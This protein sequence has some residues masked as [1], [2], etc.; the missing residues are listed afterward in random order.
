MLTGPKQLGPQAYKPEASQRQILALRDVVS[1]GESSSLTGPQTLDTLKCV[2]PVHNFAFYNLLTH[3]QHTGLHTDVGS[4]LLIMALFRWKWGMQSS[5]LR[6]TTYRVSGNEDMT[7]NG[8]IWDVEMFA[9]AVNR[10][11]LYQCLC[12]AENVSWLEWNCVFVPQVPLENKSIFSGSLFQYLEENKKW[13]NRFL[14]IPDSYNI[15]YYDN[16]AVNGNSNA[17]IMCLRRYWFG[18][19]TLDCVT[20]WT[21]PPGPGETPPAQRHHQLCRLQ[22]ADDYGAVPGPDQ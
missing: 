19:S 5:F 22:S 9:L 14:F 18:S 6:E 16:K 7:V 10:T 11:C 2:I 4:G 8:F 12:P 13:R 21:S 3:T 1:S 17:C 15:N 20:L